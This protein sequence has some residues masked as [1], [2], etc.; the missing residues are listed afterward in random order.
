MSFYRD[1][2]YEAEVPDLQSGQFDNSG[3][4]QI[5]FILTPFE[6]VNLFS[7][8]TLILYFLAISACLKWFSISILIESISSVC[9]FFLLSKFPLVIA[10]LIDFLPPHFLLQQGFGWVDR[11]RLSK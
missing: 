9:C 7:V 1:W 8:E 6:L 2:I 4:V 11:L 5:Y 3:I 10:V